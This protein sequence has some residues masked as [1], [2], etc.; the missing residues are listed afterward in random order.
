MAD[1]LLSH[2]S[3]DDEIGR[4]LDTFSLHFIPLLNVDAA[5]DNKGKRSNNNCTGGGR[6]ANKNGVDLEEK[7][8]DEPEARAVK[9]LMEERRF[10]LSLDLTGE[11]EDV[12]I[13]KGTAVDDTK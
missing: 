5:L 8:G 10:F 7:F 13:P 11:D 3:L 12:V 6:K 1:Y 2:S 9:N 4:I